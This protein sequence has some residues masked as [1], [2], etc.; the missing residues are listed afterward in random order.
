MVGIGL[1]LT[2]KLLLELQ[3]LENA[4][5]VKSE[6]MGTK[7]LLVAV[8]PLM[9]PVP[10]KAASPIA[11][12]VWTQLYSVPDTIEPVKVKGPIKVPAHLTSGGVELS[13]GVGFTVILNDCVIPAQPLA[14]GFTC[15][16]A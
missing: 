10:V 11:A 9:V 4:V 8:N 5:T 16:V 2:L 14:T 3:P 1:T 6:L 13:P 12:L 15:R 7:K